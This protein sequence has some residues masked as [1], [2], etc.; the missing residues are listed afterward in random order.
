L[1]RRQEGG[2]SYDY[3]RPLATIEP[4]A[5]A[6]GLPVDASIGGSNPDRLRTALEDPQYRKSLVVVAW[7]HKI[8]EATARGLLTAHN[9]IGADVPHWAADDF[10]SMYVVR[11]ARKGDNTEATFTLEHEGL[12]GQPDTCP[13]G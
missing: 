10:D 6:F 12:D 4:T 5:I 11:I 8:I 13:Q 1:V 9:G 7:E 3:V 2:G